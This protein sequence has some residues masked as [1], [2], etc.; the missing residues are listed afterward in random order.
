MS[1]TKA[2]EY[3]LQDTRSVVGNSLLWWAANDSGYT[4]DIRCARVWTDEDLMKRF[5]IPLKSLP[6][7]YTLHHKFAID[8][9]IQHHIDHQDLGQESP[10]TLRHWR[11]DLMQALNERSGDEKV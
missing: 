10:H 2:N 11:K 4:C 9:I 3:Y 7:K 1:E 8:R 5:D 6:G